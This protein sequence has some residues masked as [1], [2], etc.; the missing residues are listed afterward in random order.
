MLVHVPHDINCQVLQ[1]QNFKALFVIIVVHSLCVNI[2][3]PPFV[4]IVK[5]S[6]LSYFPAF[7]SL[8]TS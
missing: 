3:T 6:S 5:S 8:T 4:F 2:S 7:W 1:W